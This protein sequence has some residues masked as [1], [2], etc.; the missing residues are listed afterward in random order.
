MRITY[1]QRL[2][3]A[4]LNCWQM[5]GV[6]FL[7]LNNYYSNTCQNWT[8]LSV[9]KGFGLDRFYCI[10]VGYIFSFIIKTNVLLP[11]AQVL[12]YCRLRLFCLGPLVFLLPKNLKKNNLSC[13]NTAVCIWFSKLYN[14]I[15]YLFLP[16]DHKIV[17]QNLGD[18]QSKLLMDNTHLIVP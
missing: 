10:M 13:L 3:V 8:N 2:L 7:L 16:V 1:S 4:L 18:T 6:S 5:L 11:H 15:I 17:L 14:L 12:D 9:P